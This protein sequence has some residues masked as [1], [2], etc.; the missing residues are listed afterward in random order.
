MG[1]IIMGNSVIGKMR[2]VHDA[3]AVILVFMLVKLASK[4][5][6]LYQAVCLRS[7]VTERGVLPAI[8]TFK[9]LS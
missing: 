6:R 1:S 9:R 4:R 8:G 5:P 3:N 2:R 7:E